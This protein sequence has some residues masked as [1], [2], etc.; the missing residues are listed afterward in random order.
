MCNVYPT[1]I[2]SSYSNEGVIHEIDSE[3][4]VVQVLTASSALGYAMHRDSLYGPSP[5]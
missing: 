3:G 5:K 4:E 2:P 1:A